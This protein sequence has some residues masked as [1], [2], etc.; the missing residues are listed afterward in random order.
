MGDKAAAEL[1]G[2]DHGVT[3]LFPQACLLQWGLH[4]GQGLAKPSALR[5]L[6]GTRMVLAFV[7]SGCLALR[8][9]P[10]SFSG[11]QRVQVKAHLPIAHWLM[12]ACT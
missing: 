2:G 5:G 3:G 8:G 6:T 11:P 12:M 4:M 10:A 1:G 7:E 9:P